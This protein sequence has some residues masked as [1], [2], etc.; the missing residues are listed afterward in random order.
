MASSPLRV[1]MSD[2]TR[3]EGVNG[4]AVISKD[5]FVID[6]IITG[7]NIDP[8]ALAAMVTTLYGT[9]DR[10]GSELKLGDVDIVIV[11]YANNY[12][13][14]Q[15]IGEALFT[16]IADKR[17]ILGRIR[18]EMKRQKDRLKAAL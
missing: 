11:E 12:A 17:T 2:F 15:D 3:I 10:L 7:A 8:D 18:F 4:C 6:S 16:V 5:G 1:V 13:L 9:A 14:L